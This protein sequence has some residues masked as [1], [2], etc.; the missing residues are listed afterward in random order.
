ME[1]TASAKHRDL[2]QIPYQLEEV[3]Q[4]GPTVESKSGQTWQTLLNLYNIDCTQ[5][6]RFILYPGSRRFL[7]LH[8][9]CHAACHNMPL[10]YYYRLLKSDI[11]IKN[12]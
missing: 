2:T 4:T 5:L 9:A 1:K 12:S 7:Q 3:L 8:A 10:V 6:S 11:S